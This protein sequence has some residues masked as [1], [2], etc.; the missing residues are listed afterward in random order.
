MGQTLKLLTYNAGL[1]RFRLFGRSFFVPA[2][3]IE[4]RF[5]ALAPALLSSGAD[6]IAL[7]E[8]YD[9]EHRVGLIAALEPAYPYRAVWPERSWGRMHSG[10]MLFSKYPIITARPHWFRDIPLDERLA[11]EKGMLIAEIEAK[12][13]GH[14]SVAN[15]HHT[16]G[17]ALWDPEGHFTDGYRRRQY[18]QLFDA[19]DAGA[20]IRRLAMGDFNSGPEVAGGSFQELGASGYADAWAEKN[21][22]Q[23]MPTWEPSNSLNSAGPHRKFSAQRLDHILLSP[24]LA[25]NSIVADARIIFSDPAVQVPGRGSF[26]LSDHYGL[27][28]ELAAR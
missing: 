5:A 25:A 8:V 16:S 19:L 9:P 17:G 21:G 14:I 28:V 12:P 6:I 1:F 11:V 20:S 22:S 23:S 18:R 4:E 15:C 13:F 2:P 3:H 27:F 7:Q 10:L 24:E 26:T